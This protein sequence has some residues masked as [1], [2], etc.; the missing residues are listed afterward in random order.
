MNERNTILR[1]RPDAVQGGCVLG[2]S[3]LG[4]DFARLA[5]DT[6]SA[7]LAGCDLFHIDVMDGHFVPNLTMG[8]VVCQ[9]MRTAFPETTLDVH[10]MVD[11]PQ[12]FI[13]PFREAG[14]DHLTFHAEVVDERQAVKLAGEIRAAGMTAGLAVN[15]DKPIEPWLGIFGEFDV[16]LVMSVMPGFA[17][18]AFL[19]VA[20]ERI[21]RISSSDSPPRWISVDGGVGP[22]NVL[23]CRGAGATY[24]V[25]ASSIFKHTPQDR[26]RVVRDLKG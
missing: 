22:G 16:A 19:D 7:L 1:E 3:I 25:A 6:A 23:A 21:E 8:P 5:E 13:E 12:S 2:A 4:A 15:P 14:A 26:P 10:L 24:L 18:Q 20:V 9:A 11:D 17:G